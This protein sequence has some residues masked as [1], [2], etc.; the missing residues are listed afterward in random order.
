MHQLR[1]A[2]AAPHLQEGAAA[3]GQVVAGAHARADLVHDVQRGRLGRHQAAHLQ[4][5]L[6]VSSAGAN[7]LICS[8]GE[9]AKTRLPGSMQQ[10]GSLTQAHRDLQD[11]R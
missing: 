5:T 11:A 7:C 8:P 10:G 6:H 3:Q 9:E 4:S 1:F 2:W